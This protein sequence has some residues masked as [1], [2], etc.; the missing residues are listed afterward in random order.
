MMW[1]WALVSLAVGVAIAVALSTLLGRSERA[2]SGTYNPQALSVIGSAL[3]SSFILVTAFLIAGT[4]STYNTDRQHTYD[5]ARAATTAYWLAGK[6]PP[7]DRDRVRGELTTYVHQVISKDWPAMGDHQTSDQAYA[8]LD[9]LRADVAAIHSADATAEKKRSDLAASLDD[10]YSKRLIR[11]AD[12]NY[13]MPK[14]LYVA[15]IIAALLLIAYPPL[16]GL[17]ANGRNVVL[18]SGLGA[19]VGLGIFIVVALSHPYSE[20]LTIQPSAFRHALERF[21]QIDG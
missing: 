4:W 8:T 6:L 18:L 1:F 17:T 10:I 12:V 7:T 16:V 9:G 5:E 13:D 15:L 19:M 2:S 20:P 14:L 11:A 3:L 21:G